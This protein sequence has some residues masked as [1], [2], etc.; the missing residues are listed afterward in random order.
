MFSD[1]QLDVLRQ[2]DT[3]TMCNAI[4]LI[5]PE[6]RGLGF[7]IDPFVCHDVLAPPIV[8]YARTGTMRAMQPSGRSGDD[9][10]AAR[11]GYYRHIAEQPGPTITVI[12]DIDPHPGFGALWGEVNSNLH[13]ALGSLGVIT[14]GSIRDIDDW[15]AGFQALAGMVNPSHGW[16]HTVQYAIAVTVHGMEVHPGDLI[17]ADRHG[18]V[19]VPP[20]AVDQ[21]ASTVAA[22]ARAEARLIEPAKAGTLD[23][24]ALVEL[25]SPTGHD[26]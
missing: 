25:L 13:R 1:S 21:I 5:L 24:A 4:E 15:A 17:H 23:I 26:H 22:I 10:L 14:N 20:E 9:D 12:E 8:G 3:P 6:R 19:V 18:A 7:T 16:V 11:I 2:F